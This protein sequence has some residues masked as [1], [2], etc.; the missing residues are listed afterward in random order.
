[1]SILC[2]HR[3][4]P[5]VR[6]TS[7]WYPIPKKESPAHLVSL[8][9]TTNWRLG[10]T[11]GCLGLFPQLLLMMTHQWNSNLWINEQKITSCSLQWKH[12]LRLFFSVTHLNLLLCFLD[13]QEVHFVR[14][15]SIYFYIQWQW[16][17]IEHVREASKW[18][19]FLTF[20]SKHGLPTR[21]LLICTLLC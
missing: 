2:V 9:L 3:T 7:K 8:C 4:G 13:L 10:M 5:A 12:Q 1:M 17:H 21:T 16:P 19:H 15:P 6:K 18:L 11:L 20:L 14:P